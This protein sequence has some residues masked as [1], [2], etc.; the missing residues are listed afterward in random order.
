V[1]KVPLN[2]NSIN[3]FQIEAD[4][5]EWLDYDLVDLSGCPDHHQHEDTQP[6]GVTEV[7]PKINLGIPFLDHPVGFTLVTVPPN[8]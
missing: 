7:I 1:L 2:P 8:H 5:I 3:Q 4:D 6:D